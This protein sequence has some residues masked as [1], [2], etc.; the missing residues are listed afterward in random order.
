MDDVFL[1]SDG[2][3]GE[4]GEYEMAQRR[5]AVKGM[6]R[7]FLAEGPNPLKILKRVYTLGRGLLI[8]E[9]ATP[10]MT[11]TAAL[12]GETKGAGSWRYRR[13][14][15]LME[16]IGI[17]GTCLPGQKLKSTKAKFAAAQAGNTNRTKRRKP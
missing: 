7:Y 5:A 13:L 10:T 3:D 1:E 17:K 12:L 14:S 4:L 15:E 2:H 8:E 6:Y 16:K 11:E 9:F